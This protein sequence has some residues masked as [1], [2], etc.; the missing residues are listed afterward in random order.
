MNVKARGLCSGHYEQLRSGRELT[1]LGSTLKKYRD[2]ACEFP[3][4]KTEPR[5]RFCATHHAQNK[6]GELR[7]IKYRAAN[8]EGSINS[9]GYRKIYKPDHPNASKTSG[10]ILE[11]RYVMSQVLGRPLR[12]NEN[13]HHINGDKLDNRPENLE[14]WVTSQPKGQRVED[15]LGWAKEIIEL[16]GG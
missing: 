14:L 8:G 4:C 10:T 11:H 15:L 7:P 6:R 12:S 9:G 1:D 2:G 5:G 13:V 3:G 16:Y